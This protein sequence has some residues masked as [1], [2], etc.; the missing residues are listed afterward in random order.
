MKKLIV[1]GAGIALT[2]IV[3]AQGGMHLDQVTWTSASNKSSRVA[4][5]LE[6]ALIEGEREYDAHQLVIQGKTTEQVCAQFFPQSST[7]GAGQAD[8]KK[9]EDLTAQLQ[10]VH[11]LYQG[12]TGVAIGAKQRLDTLRLIQRQ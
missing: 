2:G 8:Y 11:E 9:V 4:G 5:N 6:R 3:F 10:A 12:S 1:L 7:C